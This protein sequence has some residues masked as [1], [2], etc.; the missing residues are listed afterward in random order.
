MGKVRKDSSKDR[1]RERERQRDR[2]QS[3]MHNS[4]VSPDSSIRSLDSSQEL[5]APISAHKR[6]RSV[7]NSLDKLADSIASDASTLL[8]KFR[9]EFDN[10]AK[11]FDLHKPNVLV[12]GCTGAGKSTLIN[13]VFGRIV[14][15]TGTGVPVTQHFARYELENESVVIYDSK[16]LEVGDHAEFIKS[17]KSFLSASDAAVDDTKSVNTL[18]TTSSKRR[19]KKH[20][21]KDSNESSR[22]SA[23]GSSE[24]IAAAHIH[25]VWYIINSA[26]SR[27]QPFEGEVCKSLFNKL[28]I[29]FILN[30]ADLSSTP[31]R[32]GLR[33]SIMD[34][35]LG[36]CIGII[37]TICTPSLSALKIPDV[38]PT[39]GSD[40]V[41]IKRK[42]KI[43]ECEDCSHVEQLTIETGLD[44]LVQRT[45]DAL[46]ALARERFVAAQRVS[47]HHKNVTARKII[48]EFH[49]IDFGGARFE[50][51]LYKVVAKMVI[52]LSILWEFREHGHEYGLEIAKEHMGQYTFRD[53]LFLMVH[54]QD[55]HQ[56]E[57]LAHTT[58]L[59]IIWNRCVR[60]LYKGLFL[61][62]FGHAPETEE[63]SSAQISDILSVCFEDL[64]SEK[65]D[66][67]GHR[68]ENEDDLATLLDEEFPRELEADNICLVNVPLNQS[69]GDNVIVT[70][71]SMHERDVAHS[72]QLA[73]DGHVRRHTNNPNLLDVNRARLTSTTGGLPDRSADGTPLPRRRVVSTSH[74]DER[75]HLS[76]TIDGRRRSD[77]HSTSSRSEMY[78]SMSTK[79]RH[80]HRHRSNMRSSRNGGHEFA[81]SSDW[82]ETGTRRRKKTKYT[83]SH[84]KNSNLSDTKNSTS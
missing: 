11:R 19:K 3:I 53:R 21:E 28:P 81:Q 72:V 67:L 54:K 66:L 83:S 35:N 14:A 24:H 74:A 12:A 25:V 73:S 84:D 9:Y 41:D 37:D 36:N 49:D 42:R 6:S 33:R 57:K 31:D 18:S 50:R 77:L 62:T 23:S 75:E 39:C 16:G 69:L 43:M 8:E 38:C 5:G 15:Q 22:S 13:K 26:G 56:D 47:M 52:R 68:V 58:A 32:E 10:A 4:S 64:N 45:M 2:K 70:R 1:S 46:P 51:Q 7:D 61:H 40:D 17:T 34:L 20:K 71:E 63:K 65:I 44:V 48:E 78:S 76:S 82:S 30:K 27:F 60:E 80:K 59:G 79:H 29:I 55:K